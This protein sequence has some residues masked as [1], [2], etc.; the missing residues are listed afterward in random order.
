MTMGTGLQCANPP[1]LTGFQLTSSGDSTSPV[2][3]YVPPTGKSD[4]SI[5]SEKKKISK[6]TR[7]Y[8]EPRTGDTSIQGSN[9]SKRSGLLSQISR[10]SID[11]TDLL[12]QWNEEED[13]SVLSGLEM[14]PGIGRGCGAV[15]LLPSNAEEDLS[16]LDGL[17]V[18]P[19]LVVA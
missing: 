18:V 9:Q 3:L 16:I 15:L 19:C 4:Q 14:I 12:L 8:F 6:K 5:V 13:L 1:S 17:E 11:P 7:S 10:D 2:A